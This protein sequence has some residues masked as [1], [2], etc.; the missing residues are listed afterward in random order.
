MAQLF[1]YALEALENTH[2]IAMRCHVDIEFGKYKLPQFP[3]PE[4]Y[5]AWTYL[6]KI[7]SEGF[8]RRYPDE[9]EAL[10]ERLTYELNTIKDMGF[11]D[12]FLIVWD[13]IKFARDHDIIVGPGRGSAAGSMVSYCL[14]ITNLDPIKYSLLFERFLNPNRVTMPDIDIDF[15]FEPRQEVIDYVVQKYG[16]DRVVQIVTF[17]TMAARGVI[18]DVGRA[19]DLP[20][21]QVDTVAKMIP[22]ESGNYH[23]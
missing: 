2:K 12:Y 13:F 18:R 4:G 3:V 9:P 6:K 15:C 14:E 17:G 22:T 10:R 8:R 16:K 1:P 23:R 21:S 11:V 7:T 20:Y 5:D 19:L